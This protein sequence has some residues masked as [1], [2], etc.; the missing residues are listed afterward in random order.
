VIAI[1]RLD[2]LFGSFRLRIDSL[3]VPR[4]GYTLIL[5]PSGA[6]KSLLLK[7]LAG[8][9][10]PDQGRVRLAGEDVTDTPPELRQ[11]GLVFQEPSLF[12]HLSVAANIAYGLKSQ[13]LSKADREA[14]V[15]SLVDDL[16]LAPLLSRPVP[17]LSGGET[18][19]VALAR[20]LAV[21]PKVLLLDEPLSQVDP[22]ARKDLR[23]ELKRLHA[24]LGLT[25]LHVTHDRAEAR[26]LG[27]A[28]A[29][30]LGGRII[31]CGTTAA[32][33]RSPVCAFVG[34]LL[35]CEG[36]PVNPPGCTEAC[37]AGTGVCDADEGVG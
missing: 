35:D 15:A 21:E 2:H 7:T 8:L 14:K 28:C 4:G 37:L 16:N 18:Q 12:P 11:V 1:D 27:D 36:K 23:A 5:G 26:D 20:A 17:S 3:E 29:V 10:R 19:K 22:H 33:S 31:Q 34:R 13:G 9:F 6:G 32:L 30:M 25:C 24:D